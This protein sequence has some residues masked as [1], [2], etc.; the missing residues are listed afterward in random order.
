MWYVG[1]PMHATMAVSL[2][3]G[4]HLATWSGEELYDQMRTNGATDIETDAD[5]ACN[6]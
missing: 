3:N 1:Y 6:S 5:M 4:L 2:D